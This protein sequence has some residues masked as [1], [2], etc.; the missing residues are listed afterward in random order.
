[1]TVKIFAARDSEGREWPPDHEHEVKA[2]IDMLKQLWTA[3][4][5]LESTY[6][7]VANMRQPNAD[8]VIF[9]ERGLG[10]VEMKHNYGK[11][12][13]LDDGAWYGGPVPIKGGSYPSP[14]HQLQ[15]YTEIL[16]NKLL[17][18]ILPDNLKRSPE[19]WDKMKFQIALCFTNPEADIAQVK[20]EV[21]KS[22][23]L[24]RKPWEGN[25]EVI[26]PTEIVPWA[27]KLRFGIDLGREKDFQP[28]R[29]NPGII[30]K[31]IGLVLGATEWTDVMSSMPNNQSYG[32]LAWQSQEGEQKFNLE[33]DEVIIGRSSECDWVTPSKFKTISNRHCKI[34][35]SL[36]GIQIED[37]ESTN[38]TYLNNKL[39]KRPIPLQNSQVVSLCAPSTNANTFRFQFFIR[40]AE[41]T[42]TSS[43]SSTVHI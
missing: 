25:F 1:M 33:K 12:T 41:N 31:V 36:Q 7:I 38:G 19:L 8:L 21:R 28:F 43:P 15:A 13:L 14:Y 18:M 3:Y 17:P 2:I 35:R 4:H 16:R 20:D 29:L 6:C 39:L 30:E 9:S 42:E 5:H 10:I 40:D 22:K 27:L 32:Y 34:T 11:I 37:L 24:E 23:H 26:D